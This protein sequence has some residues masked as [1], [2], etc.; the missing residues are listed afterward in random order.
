VRGTASTFVLARLSTVVLIIALAMPSWAWARHPD[1][2]RSA[3]L[4]D[5]WRTEDGLPQ[6]A[7]EVSLLASGGYL[8]LGTQLGLVRFNGVDFHTLDRHNTSVM[9]SSVVTDLAEAADGSIYVGLNGGGVLVLEGGHTHQIT[10][11]PGLEDAK[12]IDFDFDEQGVLWVAT[13][14]GV[15]RYLPDAGQPAARLDG[16]S[17]KLL[18]RLDAPSS[19]ELWLAPRA[20]GLVPFEDAD[21]GISAAM[22][23]VLHFA[24][25]GCCGRAPTGTVASTCGET[26]S[27]PW[28]AA[29]TSAPRSAWS[30]ACTKT[31]RA[32]CGS[33]PTAA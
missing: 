28:P 19:G 15:N 22:V 17:A 8:W 18:R 10:A 1:L 32:S 2:P 3:M 21:D 4:H 14:D 27:K 5:V 16:A 29:R 25:D 33:P 31:H 24:Q 13:L 9:A 6:S 12:V 20:G 26:A 11:I 23:R 30:P 7:I